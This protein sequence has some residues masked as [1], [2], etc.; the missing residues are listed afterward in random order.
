MSGFFLAIIP[1]GRAW[2]CGSSASARILWKSTGNPESDHFI[3]QNFFLNQKIFRILASGGSLMPEISVAKAIDEM[4]EAFVSDTTISREVSRAVKAGRLRKLASRLYTRN[5][6]DPPE[7]V[8]RRNLWN[9]VAGYSRCADRRPHG[10]GE[11]PGE[12]RLRLPGFRHG[13]RHQAAGVYPAT[14]AGCCSARDR[15]SLHRRPIPQ[16]DGSGLFGK[17]APVAHA[18]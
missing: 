3:S 9:I 14:S 7:A 12:R 10:A 16:F 13:A 18:R 8:V 6:T 17:H 1:C 4:P 2:R 15:P 11:R 5:L